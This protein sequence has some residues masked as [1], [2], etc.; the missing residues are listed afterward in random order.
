MIDMEA[1][2]PIFF[3]LDEFGT[4]VLCSTLAKTVTALVDVGQEYAD[5]QPNVTRKIATVVYKNSDLIGLK[6]GD[7]FFFYGLDWTVTSITEMDRVVSRADVRSKESI[8]L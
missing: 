6:P 1:D 5:G 3:D 4:Q 7:L 2:L 8:T